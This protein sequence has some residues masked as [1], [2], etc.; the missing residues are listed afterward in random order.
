MIAADGLLAR[1]HDP[2]MG[3]GTVASTAPG[4]P[5]DAPA[6]TPAAPLSRWVELAAGIAIVGLMLLVAS[7]GQLRA[8]GT[9]SGQPDAT[10]TAT[11]AASPRSATAAPPNVSDRVEIMFR[12]DEE[13][14]GASDAWD[15]NVASKPAVVAFPTSFD[16]SL[17]LGTA[18]GEPVSACRTIHPAAV[19][20][21]LELEFLLDPAES[22]VAGFTIS[23][24]DGGLI[25]ESRMAKTQIVVSASDGAEAS[26]AG[27]ADGGWYRVSVMPSPEGYEVVLRPREL[28]TNE[29][30][31][32]RLETQSVGAVGGI[33]LEVAG[34][35]GSS[36]HYDNLRI[37]S[38][39]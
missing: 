35:A 38:R 20:G 8:E 33:C 16:R 37:S 21:D 5:V 9:L 19:L 31:V 36:V 29:Q 32:I 25:L 26:G 2:V 13:R 27:A 14:I 10:A 23:D 3:I 6:H 1:H 12:F 18:D 17:Q 28:T 7:Q 34:A 4:P 24:P 22:A 30:S 15:V 39:G 11:P